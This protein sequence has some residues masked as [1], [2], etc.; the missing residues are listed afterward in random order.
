MF[1]THLYNPEKK[2]KIFLTMDQFNQV[3][4]D[5]SNYIENMK[6]KVS[7][8]LCLLCGDLNLG[9]EEFRDANKGFFDFMERSYKTVNSKSKYNTYWTNNKGEKDVKRDYILSKSTISKKPMFISR[10]IAKE[11][12]DHLGIISEISI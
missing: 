6:E 9:L 2:H 12:S 10:T 5:I 4:A 7:S 11:I 3:R 1:N 8:T